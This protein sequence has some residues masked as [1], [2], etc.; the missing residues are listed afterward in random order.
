MW[1]DLKRTGKNPDKFH[2][3]A[4]LSFGSKTVGQSAKGMKKC[5]S[6]EKCKR[7][8]II[9]QTMY[10]YFPEINNSIENTRR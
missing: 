8:P 1:K 5:F 3:R 10:T 2:L 6:Y 4:V 7:I 9:S